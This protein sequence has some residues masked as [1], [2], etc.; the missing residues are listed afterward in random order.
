MTSSTRNENPA[1]REKEEDCSK[2]INEMDLWDPFRKMRKMQRK[3][4]GFFPEDFMADTRQPLI[5]IIDKGKKLQ[6]TAELPGMDKKNIDLKVD[7]RQL[8][9]SAEAKQETKDKKEGYYHH[10]RSYQKFFRQVPLPAEIMTQEAKAE[11]KNGIL[12]I[13]LPKKHPEKKE[14]GHKIRVE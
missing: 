6:V 4:L 3:T 9:I 5:D 12:S 10:E 1:E 13:E 7:D 11:F 8:Q 14:K 2:M